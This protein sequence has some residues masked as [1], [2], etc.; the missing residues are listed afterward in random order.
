MPI[1]RVQA[2]NGKVY[3]VEGPENADPNILFQAAQQQFDTEETKRLQK[4][5]GPG[6]FETFTRGVKRG[7]GEFGSTITDIIPAM[8]ASA[9]GFDEYAK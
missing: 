4:E 5:Y 2:P 8:G 3:R 9:L 7:A 6:I 1:Y